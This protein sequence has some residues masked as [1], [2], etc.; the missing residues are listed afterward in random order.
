LTPDSIGS[1]YREIFTRTLGPDLE[2]SDRAALGWARIPH[3]YNAYYVY[4]YATGYASAIALSRR[5]LQGG[6]TER[7]DYL[8]FLSAGNSDYPIGILRRAGVDLARPDAVRDTFDLFAS[9]LDRLE[10]HVTTHGMAPAP[11]GRREGEP[12]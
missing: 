11:A 3:F 12:S 6:G 1:V 4:Q 2:F 5:V 9:L 7:A 10:E 8:G